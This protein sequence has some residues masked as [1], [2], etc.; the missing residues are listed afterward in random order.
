[1]ETTHNNGVPPPLD[2]GICGSPRVKCVNE[3]QEAA[4]AREPHGVDRVF[5]TAAVAPEADRRHVTTQRRGEQA[6]RR[7]AREVA[8]P[9]YGVAARAV[10]DLFPL[11]VVPQC[12]QRRAAVSSVR[13]VASEGC[14]T[15]DAIACCKQSLSVAA[16]VNCTRNVLHKW[17]L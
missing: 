5:S 1:M 16:D 2:A 17:F 15:R 9:S 12:L 10:S 7:P 8:P 4:A 11:A 3:R 13:A 14:S 6:F